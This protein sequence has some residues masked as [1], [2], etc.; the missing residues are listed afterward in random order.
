[1]EL[2][3]DPGELLDAA[4]ILAGLVHRMHSALPSGWLQPAGQDADSHAAVTGINPRYESTVN[5][6]IQALNGI[7]P[8]AYQVGAAAVDYTRADQSGAE[9]LGGGAGGDAPVNRVALPQPYAPRSAPTMPPPASV[10]VD[11]LTFAQQLHS[12][13]G[14]APA[15]ALANAIRQYRAGAHN[16]GLDELQR[17]IPVL[18]N[19]TPVG[20][21]VAAHMSD[22]WQQLDDL[23]NALDAHA[24]SIDDYAN[25][26]QTAKNRHPTPQ[27]IQA[28]RNK[29][30]AAIR[31]K[32]AAAIEQALAEF[33]EHNARSAQTAADYTA[34]LG[35]TA[36]DGKPTAGGDP[37]KTGNP[38]TTGS[39]PTKSGTTSANNANS[40]AS[41]LTQLLPTLLSSLTG[42]NSQLSQHDPTITDPATDQS[43]Y[44]DSGLPTI[45][46]L[47]D[48]GGPSGPGGDPGSPSIPSIA[49]YDAGILP[50][51]EAPALANTATVARAPVID[52]LP[53]TATARPSAGTGYSPPYMPMSP[54][55]AGAAGAN[56]RSRVVAWHPDRLMYVDDTAH[57]EAVIGEKP[58]IAPSVTPPTPAPANHAPTNTGGST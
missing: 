35:T 19:W 8:H 1:M 26:F 32:N 7:A 11:P 25:A 17:T 29:L 14:T 15:R 43:P 33:N 30:L 31:S 37:T 24:T 21:M 57:T 50:V 49:P 40:D 10:A 34:A 23:G 38:A 4:A 55:M 54:G 53:A 13:P 12:G 18:N 2:N 3:V 51:V 28:T 45:P 52:A 47:S 36:G 27:E 20:T 42:A 48:L 46:A 41:M 44:L 39:G 6:L 58:T 5:D 16:S 9:L 56:N 22:F